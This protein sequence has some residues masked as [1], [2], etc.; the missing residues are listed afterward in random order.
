MD[1]GVGVEVRTGR[2]RISEKLVSGHDLT[3]MGLEPGPRYKELLD[4][5]REAQLDGTI[6]TREEA[7]AMLRSLLGEDPVSGACQFLIGTA[8][9]GTG[10]PPTSR[11]RIDRLLESQTISIS[12]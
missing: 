10:W 1:G 3:A 9:R 2:K 8:R 5:V 11:E 6:T 4:R 7:L 12:S